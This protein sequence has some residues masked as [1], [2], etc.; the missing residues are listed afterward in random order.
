MQ[1]RRIGEEIGDQKA[2]RQV[3]NRNNQRK[4]DKL[5]HQE[6]KLNKKQSEYYDK[7]KTSKKLH[8]FIVV[9]ESIES[10]HD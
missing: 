7:P 3:K 4:I 9:F 1:I 5:I 6:H 2:L 10:R 8:E